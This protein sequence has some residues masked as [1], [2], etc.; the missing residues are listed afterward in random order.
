MDRTER[1]IAA[2]A[3]VERYR[4]DRDAAALRASLHAL[5]EGW[6]VTEITQLAEHYRD[7][8]EVSIVLYELVLTREPENASALVRLGNAYW[9]SGRGPDAVAK[10]ASEA[11]ARDPSNRGAWHLWALSEADLRS[12][13]ARWEQVTKRFP[14]DDLALAA[15]AD[16]AASLAGAE[17]DREMLAFAIGK[18]E[19]LLVRCTTGEQRAAVSA[20]LDALR[21]WQL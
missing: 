21:S 8:V 6:S 1:E 19:E 15:L 12:R 5:L 7:E 4:Q 11:I 13:I 2:A 17:R 16:N 3:V 18:Y 9:L 10:L 20:A 14:A